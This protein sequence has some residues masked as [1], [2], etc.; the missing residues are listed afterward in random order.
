MSISSK[1]SSSSLKK[2]KELD[3]LAEQFMALTLP[4]QHKA[5]KRIRGKWF[6]AYY[7]QLVIGDV[8][9]TTSF[10][11]HSSGFKKALN[12]YYKQHEKLPKS[13]KPMSFITPSSTPPYS[14]HGNL[15]ERGVLHGGDKVQLI[16]VVFDNKDNYPFLKEGDQSVSIKLFLFKD[17]SVKDVIAYHK[18]DYTYNLILSYSK[19]RFV[20]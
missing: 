19:E 14:K 16:N 1:T 12:H 17:G 18:N 6:F 4:R 7:R 9:Y 15:V 5:R 8:Y 13:V 10:P 3:A 20:L 2:L 11:N